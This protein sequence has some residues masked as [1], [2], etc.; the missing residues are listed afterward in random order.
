MIFQWQLFALLIVLAIL[1]ELVGMRYKVY[2]NTGQEYR[3]HWIIALIIAVP[4]IVMAGR[5]IITMVNFGDTAAYLSG[6]RNA[7]TTILEYLSSVNDTSKDIGFTVVTIFL[8]KIIGNSEIIYFTLIAA[9]CIVCVVYTYRKFSYNFLISIF[10][11]IASADYLQWSYNGIRQFIP[12]A[13]LFACSGLLLKQ[14]YGQLLIIILVL[15]TIHASA[16]IFIP[17]MFIVQGKP[18]NK[19]TMLFAMGIVAAIA[20]V[21]NFT[22]LVTTLMENSQYAG[23]VDQ[24]LSTEGTN[25]LRVLVYSIPAVLTFFFRNRIEKEDNPVINL[26]TNMSIVAALCYILSAFTSGIFLG[27]IPIYFSLY[28]YMV[29]PWIIERYFTER[30]A[31]LLYLLMVGAYMCFYYYQVH[32]TWMLG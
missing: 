17:I 21:D 12:V 8:K 5:R 14:K 20:F 32:V 9:I 6:F 22:D 10:L 1:S 3:Y 26:A 4:M 28:G 2:D 31:K 27:R 24:Y 19:K 29:I 23:E 16:L 13:I 25:V 30:S 11:F 15:S 18:W 7:P